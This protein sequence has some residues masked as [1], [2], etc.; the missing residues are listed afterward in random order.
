MKENMMNNDKNRKYFFD[1]LILIYGSG[2]LFY[3][4]IPSIIV[5]GISFLFFLYCYSTFSKEY[6][7]IECLS[8]ISIIFIPTSTIS[9]LGTSYSS[10]PL[11]WYIISILL[12]FILIGLQGKLDKKYFVF[13]FVFATVELVQIFVSSV[14]VFNALKQYLI[15]ILFLFGFLIGKYLKIF[16]SD[17]IHEDVYHYYLIGTFCLAFQVFLQRFYIITLGSRIGHYAVMGQGR[18]AY[19]GLMGD[20]SF[21]TLYLASGCLIV[22]LKH[23][24]TKE[25][26]FTKFILYEGFLLSAILAVSSRTGLVA[27]A[28]TVFLYFA[29][30]FRQLNSKLV[31]VL[32]I[33]VVAI[34]FLFEKLMASRGSQAL[35]DSSGRLDNYIKALDY[36]GNRFLFG[37]GLG[38]DNLY[39]ATGLRVP[40]NFFI[41]YLVQ[42]GVV[43]LVLIII[44]V[45]WFFINDIR[46]SSYDKWLFLLIAIGSMFIPDIV[47]SR[48]IYG[49]ILIC[50][51]GVTSGDTEVLLEEEI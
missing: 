4:L 3:S 30:N 21:A 36:W 15:I 25:I 32:L 31:L 8:L 1:A 35:L 19:A 18:V 2:M 22:L 37:Y 14:S 20:Y 11:T 49:I 46:K 45:F 16:S 51:T 34:P 26:G 48:Y 39:S 27:L 13:T 43:G 23:L 5:A 33:C 24:N 41:Q 40:H 12:A 17:Y 6:S 9:I 7:S 10:L 42:I 29:F 28:V 50:M 38:L 44:P 47:S